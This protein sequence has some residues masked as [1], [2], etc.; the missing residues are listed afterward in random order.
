MFAIFLSKKMDP[1]YEMVLSFPAVIFSGLFVFCMMYGLVAV[2]GMVDIDGLDLDLDVDTDVDAGLD[3]DIDSNAG[4]NILGGLI[5]KFGLEGV[6]FIFIF[7]VFTI[8]GW[9]VSCLSFRFIYPY[10]PNVFY[11]PFGCFV[12]F[13]SSYAGLKF[14]SLLTKPFE[15]TLKANLNHGK[16]KSFLGQSAK[17][18]TSV[19]NETFGEAVLEDGGA[20]LILKV[21]SYDQEFKRDDK[22]ILIEYLEDKNV[23]GVISEKEFNK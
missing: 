19:V 8:V 3:S 7:Y 9:V 4:P 2:L 22:V 11:Y 14:A 17:V 12:L 20:G 5:L 1:F 15:K 21:R 18:R 13:Y 10:V 6:P 23:Y 16:P